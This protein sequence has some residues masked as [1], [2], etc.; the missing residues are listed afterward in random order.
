MHTLNIIIRTFN[1]FCCHFFRS[2]F[3]LV[4][5]PGQLLWPEMDVIL[6]S[7]FPH[8]CSSALSAA[9][10]VDMNRAGMFIV[11]LNCASLLLDFIRTLKG[12]Y[13][14]GESADEKNRMHMNLVQISRSHCVAWFISS[15][16]NTKWDFARDVEDG[17]L[18]PVPRTE[19]V[20]RF[21]AVS[22]ATSKHHRGTDCSMKKGTSR[23]EDE[24]LFFNFIFIHSI[25][26]AYKLT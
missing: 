25:E 19:S 26:M 24:I 18:H 8:I 2:Y 11:H 9:W 14:Y 10:T 22:N 12:E 21:L 17:I 23:K 15:I 6:F 20:T 5:F 1:A 7:I 16:K 4:L 3:L 13:Q